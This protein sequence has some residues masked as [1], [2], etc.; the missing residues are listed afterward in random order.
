L[1]PRELDQIC[2]D[3]GARRV[4]L[5][6]DVSKETALITPA[7]LAAERGR[8]GPFAGIGIGPLNEIAE[9]EPVEADAARQVAAL[10]YTSGTTGQP[11]PGRW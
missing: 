10:M 9:Q 11:P 2:A 1:T 6:A 5:T 7:R 8:V 4:L 3:S